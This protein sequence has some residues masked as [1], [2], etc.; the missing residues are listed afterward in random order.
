M[1]KSVIIRPAKDGRQG[2][3]GQVAPIVTTGANGTGQALVMEI[4]G[5]YIRLRDAK[6]G[7]ITLVLKGWEHGRF[8]KKR[9]SF[10][11]LKR[12]AA[13]HL[14]DTWEKRIDVLVVSAAAA[15][16]AASTVIEILEG[17]EMLR[18]GMVELAW[19]LFTR[20]AMSRGLLGRRRG[21]RRSASP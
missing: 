8:N 18:T 17:M 11:W 21:C 16:R 19:D 9:G 12:P 3:E 7:H 15:L 14:N 2:G 10:N 1:L 6:T 5:E 20:S 4:M 13:K